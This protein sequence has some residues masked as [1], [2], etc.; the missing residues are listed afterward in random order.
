MPTTATATAPDASLRLAAGRARAI[1]RMPYLR[2][3]LM[4][5]KPV[6][7][8]TDSGLSTLAVDKRWRMY[9]N[10]VFV[11]SCDVEEMAGGWLHEVGHPL[12]EHD[13]R[14]DALSEPRERHP[15]FNKAGDAAI[16]ADLRECN[17]TL[18]RI[19]AY[20]PERIAGAKRESTTEQMYRLLLNSP[21]AAKIQASLPEIVAVPGAVRHDYADNFAVQ[22]MTRNPVLDATVTAE[23]IDPTT[24]VPVTG[25]LNTVSAVSDRRAAVHLAQGVAPGDYAIKVSTTS[26]DLEAAFSIVPAKITVRPDHIERGYAAPFNTVIDGQLTNFDAATTVELLDQGGNVVP[27]A[28]SNIQVLSASVMRMD[29]PL[30]PDG[31]Y[32]VQ[33]TEAGAAPMSAM[34]P[35]GLPFLDITPAFLPVGYGT[36][37]PVAGIGSDIAFDA[38]STVEIMALTPFGIVPV[39]GAASAARVLSPTSVNFDLIDSLDEGQY[40][41]VVTG[42]ADQAVATLT[43]SKPQDGDG[44]G[45]GSGGDGQGGGSDGDGDSDSDGDGDGGSKSGKGGKGKGKG[46]GEGD[47]S[48]SDDCGSGSGGGKRDWEKGDNESDDGSISEGR[49]MTI[50]QQ[51]ARDIQ[52]HVKHGRGTVPAGWARWADEILDPQVDWRKE[53]NSVV[54]RTFATVAGRK[55]YSYARPGRRTATM[56][57]VVLPSMRQPRPPSADVIVDTSGSMRDKDLA[58]V[59]GEI[60]AIADRVS[61]RGSTLRVRSCDADAAQ[62]QVIRTVKHITLTGGGGTDMRV[63]IKAAAQERPKSDMIIILTDGDTP[64]PTEPDPANPTA[65]YIAVLVRG[66]SR[67]SEVPAWMHKIVINS[68]YLDKD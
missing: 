44:E 52:D 24:K 6:D 45:G 11:N 37:Y 8:G 66:E 5:L 39:Q 34:L 43:I 13:R 61:K 10:P 15:L 31:M 28:V 57:G 29:L 3:A 36:P 33:V 60:A 7:V 38:N 40:L 46:E 30:L 2:S 67:Y 14:W 22:I 23:L 21:E 63:G 47:G 58:Q 32:S 12:R 51:V 48:E 41:V 17:V 19:K 53:L 27:G 20:Y 62:A 16:N 68:D 25:A 18:P 9:Y 50:R 59:L 49:A 64:W 4:A 42:G 65:K 35:I 1:E 56:N 54:R 55:D 26:G